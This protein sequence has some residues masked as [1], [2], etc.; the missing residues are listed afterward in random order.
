MKRE[1]T[2]SMYKKAKFS[3]DYSDP[4]EPEFI[5]YYDASNN[6]A[7]HEPFFTIDVAELIVAHYN[8]M[9]SDNPEAGYDTFKW[10][11]DN[12]L[13]YQHDIPGHTTIEPVH[14]KYGNKTLIVYP[15]GHGSWSWEH[16]NI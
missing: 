4:T 14:I 16:E 10:I 9:S 5:G 7:F 15:I 3:V 2:N 6:D 11:G 1:K 12:I 8:S 13:W